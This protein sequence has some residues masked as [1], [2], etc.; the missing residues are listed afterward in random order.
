VS[1]RTALVGG[2]TVGRYGSHVRFHAK[3]SGPGQ[4]N[5][6]E[7]K[8]SLSTTLDALLPVP[9][10]KDPLRGGAFFVKSPGLNGR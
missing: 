4:A 9:L 10:L 8:V 7:V 6:R 3:A 5:L 1:R 2:S